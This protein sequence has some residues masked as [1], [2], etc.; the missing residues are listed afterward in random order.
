M[1]NSIDHPHSK[2]GLILLKKFSF[3][4]YK[5]LLRNVFFAF[6]YGLLSALAINLFLSNA[7]SYSVG[8]TGIAQL[9]QAI[10]ATKSIVVSMS[11]L[12]IIFN[13]P[14]FFFAWRVFG[15]N[16]IAYSLLAVG[17][18]IICLHIIPQAMIVNDQLTNT[19]VG[20]ALVGI[21]IGFCFNNGFSTGGT[22][23]IVNYI[24][25]HYHKKIGFLSN[26]LN[27]GTLLITALFFDLGRSVYSLLGMLI[28][29][30]LMDTVFV[31]QKDV[32]ILI[33]TKN[34][35]P[36]IH[37]LKNF[38]HGATLVK[39]TG[40]YT[41]EATDIIII[42]AQKGQLNYLKQLVQAI[43]QNAFLSTQATDADLGNY[44]RVFEN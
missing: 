24:Q 31:L 28:T 4:K 21:G 34:S 22:D 5:K 16:Y 32:N 36:I 30:Y 13:V 10:L 39:G 20:S 15:F 37:A 3:F 11:T 8:V 1:Y 9:L 12:L 44:R 33:F 29:S 26:L 6:F 40:I 7:Q 19:L 14:L 42:V 38:V 43:D 17:S 23:I 25:L 41:G 2:G 18:N 35:T 27:S